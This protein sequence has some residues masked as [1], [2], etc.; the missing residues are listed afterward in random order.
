MNPSDDLPHGWR[1]ATDEEKE[2]HDAGLLE[3]PAR[4]VHGVWGYDLAI[5]EI[6]CTECEEAIDPDND[7]CQWSN[8]K[9]DWVCYG[10]YESDLSYVSTVTYI[11]PG[12]DPFK[13][14]VGDLTVMN[15]WGD[16]VDDVRRGYTHTDGWRGYHTTRL[17]GW[18][19]IV[20]GWTTGN[21]G[22][23]TGARKATFNEWAEALYTGDL[24][25]P[26][27]IAVVADP[28]SNVF[29]TAVGVW[30][31][32]ENVDLFNEWLGEEQHEEL[33]ASLS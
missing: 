6:K 15:E 4:F 32:D 33:Y 26:C 28:T 1:W 23:G 2:E 30:V 22:D 13:V 9:E 18:T 20:D 12:D 14:Y 16:E 5:S 24:E 29:S 21:W 8:V 17:D 10:C 3:A 19:E 11:R 7:D 25:A 27:E 31:A